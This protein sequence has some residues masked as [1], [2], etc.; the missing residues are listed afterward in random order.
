MTVLEK[1]IYHMIKP[2]STS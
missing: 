2:T 1:T